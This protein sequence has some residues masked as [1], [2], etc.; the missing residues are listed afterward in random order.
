MTHAQ[1][2]KQPDPHAL[3]AAQ[4]YFELGMISDCQSTLEQLPADEKLRPDSL[5]LSILLELDTGRHEAALEFCNSAIKLY[6]KAPFGF[7][8]KAFALHELKRTPESLQVLEDAHLVVAVDPT[9][10]YN[11]GCYLA[12]LNRH[13]EA[14]Y[15][16][17]KAIRLN[18]KLRDHASTD[19]D[20]QEIEHRLE[21]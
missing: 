9:A 7:I 14:I 4:G 11:R 8:N 15:C 21:P 5:E 20:L 18:P 6:P 19:K 17:N 13:T 3:R 2:E 12:C 1:L 16:V 10:I